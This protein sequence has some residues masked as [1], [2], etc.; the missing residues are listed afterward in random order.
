M[1]GAVAWLVV[2]AVISSP[3]TEIVPVGVAPV[4]CFATKRMESG[5]KCLEPARPSNLSGG[6]R[7]ARTRD[8]PGVSGGVLSDGQ[9][10]SAAGSVA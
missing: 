6:S 10:R 9:P 4:H 8:S 2:V 1:G 7:P 3:M 5:V